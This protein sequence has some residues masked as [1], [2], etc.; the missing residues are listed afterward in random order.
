MH[1]RS[2]VNKDTPYLKG[3]S[4]T[5]KDD[6][7]TSIR[8]LPSACREQSRAP[9]LFLACMSLREDYNLKGTC[10]HLWHFSALRCDVSQSSSTY[11]KHM[12]NRTGLLEMPTYEAR[13]RA[14]GGRTEWG[15]GGWF[16]AAFYLFLFNM[17]VSHVCWCDRS[18]DTPRQKVYFTAARLVW[19]Q[20]SSKDWKQEVM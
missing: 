16:G 1:R 9:W 18:T 17:D 2:R 6:F 20:C 5:S 19:K 15:L 13:K 4:N 3:V 14:S 7:M 8:H 10:S 12:N 11:R